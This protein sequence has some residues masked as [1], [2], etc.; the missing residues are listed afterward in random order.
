MGGRKMSIFY[1]PFAF[2]IFLIFSLITMFFLLKIGIKLI[3]LLL[4]FIVSLALF[5][6]FPAI[7]L[8]FIFVF[9]PLFILLKLIF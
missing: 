3:F 2:V 7:L 9:L 8:I 6:V 5:L 1:G 4:G